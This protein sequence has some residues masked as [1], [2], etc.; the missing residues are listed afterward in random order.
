MKDETHH[1]LRHKKTTINLNPWM[2]YMNW[3]KEIFKHQQ[4]HL[5]LPCL[6]HANNIIVSN[7]NHKNTKNW[8]HFD[9]HDQSTTPLPHTKFPA[10]AYL[11]VYSL[12]FLLS[13]WSIFSSRS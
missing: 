10:I 12:Q 9:K 2:I 6:A 5:L 11:Q 7:V 13:W 8:V 1:Q 4:H 3:M